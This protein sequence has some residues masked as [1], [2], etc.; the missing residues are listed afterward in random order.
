MKKETKRNQSYLEDATIKECLPQEVITALYS[1]TKKKPHNR[2]NHKP[3]RRE[4]K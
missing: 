2:Q 3:K 4:K 1:M